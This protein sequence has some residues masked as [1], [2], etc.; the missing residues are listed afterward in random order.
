MGELLITPE[1]SVPDHS[2][3]TEEYLFV[4]SGGGEITIDGQTTNITQGD[5]VYIK[6]NARMAF[7]NH[8]R[9][10]TRLIQFFAGPAPAAK[11]KEDDGT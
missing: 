10:T 1:T 5:A 3:A 11:Y 4:L 2:D 8:E 7:W 9:S 6:A